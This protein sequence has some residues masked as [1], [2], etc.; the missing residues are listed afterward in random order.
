MKLGWKPITDVTGAPIPLYYDYEIFD[1]PVNPLTGEL[2]EQV[3]MGPRYRHSI[4]IHKAFANRLLP[5]NKES[6]SF[7]EPPNMSFINQIIK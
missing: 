5:N 6:Y 4:A 2:Y 3:Y 1:L 7:K